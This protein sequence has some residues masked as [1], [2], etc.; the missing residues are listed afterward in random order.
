MILSFLF[1]KIGGILIGSL[2][3]AALAFGGKMYLSHLWTK[4]DRLETEIASKEAENQFLKKAAQID[5]D[6]REHKDEIKKT[7]DSGDPV[8]I[9][10]LLDRLRQLSSQAPN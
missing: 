7:I 6:L 5:A 4:V 10:R 8:R 9:K 1:S 3:L 2:L